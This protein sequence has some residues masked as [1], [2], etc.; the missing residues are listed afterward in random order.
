M[1]KKIHKR[2]NVYSFFCLGCGGIH[3]FNDSWKVDIE[4][5][6]VSPSV[7]VTVPNKSDPRCHSFI[8]NGQI[9]YLSDCSHDLKN[10]TIDLPEFKM[11]ED[12]SY[13]NP[14]GVTDDD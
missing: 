6:T 14:E 5:L 3:Q 1:I 11:L 2:K 9:Q 8:K 7:L 13:W 12:G 4:N 10:K